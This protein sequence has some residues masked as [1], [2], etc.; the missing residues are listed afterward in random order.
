M[1][2]QDLKNVSAFEFSA[3]VDEVITNYRYK[4]VKNS[5]NTNAVSITCVF[6]AVLISLHRYLTM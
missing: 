4:K 5:T 1:V 3:Q 6:V 2:K